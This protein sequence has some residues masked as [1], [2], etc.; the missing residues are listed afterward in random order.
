MASDNA[1]DHIN[2]NNLTKSDHFSFYHHYHVN[3]RIEDLNFLLGLL[4]F[5]SVRASL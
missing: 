5:S 3:Y 2:N 4:S 1:N